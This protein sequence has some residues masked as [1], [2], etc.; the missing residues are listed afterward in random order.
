MPYLH[1]SS[2][3]IAYHATNANNTMKA[4]GKKGAAIFCILLLCGRLCDLQ[5]RAFKAKAIAQKM[6]IR[7]TLNIKDAYHLAAF[8]QN[9]GTILSKFTK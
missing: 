3:I 9:M 8:L 4:K 1:K 7:D 2:K 6:K 5:R